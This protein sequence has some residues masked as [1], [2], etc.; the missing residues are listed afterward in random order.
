MKTRPDTIKG[1]LKELIDRCEGCGTRKFNITTYKVFEGPKK[2]GFFGSLGEALVPADP[3]EYRRY[4]R[5]RERENRSGMEVEYYCTQCE[6]YYVQFYS[7]ATLDVFAA[8]FKRR[9]GLE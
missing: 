3:E 8:N 4:M 9:H 6:E 2:K 7:R 5:R 1:V